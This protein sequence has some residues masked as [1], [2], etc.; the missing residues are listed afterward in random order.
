MTTQRITLKRAVKRGDYVIYRGT[1][2]I[3]T[4]HDHRRN[5]ERRAANTTIRD[6]WALCW[7]TGRVDWHGS[8]YEARDN[9]LKGL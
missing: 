8:F 5:P 6:N 7:L 9:A 3:A 4:L 2:I 1:D